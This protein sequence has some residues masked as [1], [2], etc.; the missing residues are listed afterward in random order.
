M[1]ALP[2]SCV[3]T[4]SDYLYQA[5]CNFRIDHRSDAH[6]VRRPPARR[7]ADQNLGEQ[8]STQ[9]GSGQMR[10]EGH[11]IAP[12]GRQEHVPTENR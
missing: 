2:G 7:P 6:V 12:Y 9:H 3:E 10:W 5:V 1:S 8:A 11:R 4:P